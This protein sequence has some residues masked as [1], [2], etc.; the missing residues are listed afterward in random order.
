[1]VEVGSLPPTQYLLLDTLAARYRT[2]EHT[3]TLP[4]MPGIVRAAHHLARLGLV[5]VKSGVAEKTIQVWLT[6]VGEAAVLLPGWVN[7]ADGARR[8]AVAVLR[9]FTGHVDGRALLWPRELGEEPSWFAGHAI[10][11]DPVLSARYGPNEER[12]S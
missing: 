6:E 9:H 3:W 10:L 12:A 5:G 2:G 4:T 1:M 7:P 8:I 11:A